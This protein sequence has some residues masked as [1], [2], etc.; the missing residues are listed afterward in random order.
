MNEMPAMTTS[1]MQSTTIGMNQLLAQANGNIVQ[2]YA[3][4]R[5]QAQPTLTLASTGV[6]KVANQQRR[7]VQVFIC[8]PNENVPLPDCL[9][10][11]GDQKLTDLTDQELFFEIDIRTIL[12]SH[13]EKRV[14]MVDKAVKERI[15]YLE[16]ARIRDLKM[17]VVNIA[18]F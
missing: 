4:Q 5:Q 8:D 13:N 12:A 6:F 18:T 1:A 15:E 9:I 2:Q 14:K 10:Y 16:A 11:R 17:T 7:L 3:V